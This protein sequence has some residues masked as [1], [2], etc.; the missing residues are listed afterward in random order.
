MQHIKKVL[1]V[2]VFTVCDLQNNV[3]WHWAKL[4]M[5]EEKEE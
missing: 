2:G 4:E 5:I 1:N 3:N